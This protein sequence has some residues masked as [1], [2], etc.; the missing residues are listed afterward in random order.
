LLATLSLIVIRPPYRTA[1]S[2]RTV[3][4]LSPTATRQHN[5]PLDL[6]F[7]TASSE[8]K[9]TERTYTAVP[10]MAPLSPDLFPSCVEAEWP[11]LESMPTEVIWNVIEEGQFSV[12]DLYSVSLQCRK[13]RYAAERC[14]YSSFECTAKD[15]RDDVVLPLFLR[16][17]TT[18]P[19][20]AQKVERVLLRLS[21]HLRPRERKPS[22]ALPYVINHV[23][24]ALRTPRPE[25]HVQP[26]KKEVDRDGLLSEFQIAVDIGNVDAAAAMI[27][28]HLPNLKSLKIEFH[29]PLEAWFTLMQ[30]VSKLLTHGQG[31]QFKTTPSLTSLTLHAPPHFGNVYDI[32]GIAI[33]GIETLRKVE[34]QNINFHGPWVP[35]C[36]PVTDVTF[37]DFP[38]STGPSLAT[39]RVG[40]ASSAS[41]PSCSISGSSG[42]SNTLGGL[43]TSPRPGGSTSYTMICLSSSISKTLLSKP[44]F[45]RP[46]TSTPGAVHWPY[47]TS[48][49]NER[50]LT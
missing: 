19:E 7:S 47:V 38:V 11:S 20:L 37:L 13:L 15:T 29:D 18:R 46:C 41:S 44:T 16:T 43:K 48:G 45:S 23:Y 10:R 14:L 1:P 30:H 32:H 8:S 22:N 35:R 2:T 28:M 5:R 27:M 12:H 26:A 4:R 42:K 40:R 34:L 3:R 17:I 36:S 25:C 31:W 33:F 6:Q 49:G 24:G 50:S 39:I 21:P 9:I